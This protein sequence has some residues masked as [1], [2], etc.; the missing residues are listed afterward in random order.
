MA[1][2]FN[3]SQLR[4]K[5]T[6]IQNK[7][8]SAVNRYNQ[9]V[10]EYNRKVTH[11]VN[12]YNQ[13]VRQHNA[14]VKANRQRLNSAIARLNSQTSI[15]YSATTTSS[16]RLY[17]SYQ[18]LDNRFESGYLNDRYGDW[19][20][21]AEREAA[22]SAE[23]SKSLQV[24]AE[25]SQF[26]GPAI[27]SSIS[28]EL[29]GIS[30]DLDNRWKGAIF[31]LNPQNP[32]AA[33]H[34]CTSSREVIVQLI[35]LKAS[36]EE[37]KENYPRIKLTENGKPSRRSKIEYLLHRNQRDALADFTEADIEDIMLLFRDFNNGTHGSAGK[38]SYDQLLKLKNRVEDSIKY[39]Y[40]VAY[41]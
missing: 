11:A 8:R 34:F 25:S 13:A 40:Q 12:N 22:N 4:S 17:Q 6:Q 26:L 15:R 38:Y 30:E 21:L 41:H 16:Y 35:E 20:D 28:N 7:Q 19:V 14:R 32:D 10:R 18:E 33:R 5:L 23:L 31:S 24:P 2:K 39:L 3:A 9:K 37:V 27:T 1:K 29:K 36:D